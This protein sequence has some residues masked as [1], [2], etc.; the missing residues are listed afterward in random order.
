[1]NRPPREPLDAQERAL[2]A[3]LP[4]PHGRGEPGAAID[5]RI[6]A[7][8]RSA[9]ETAPRP[10]HRRRWIAPLGVA[11]TVIV[12]A[13][14]AWRLLPPGA[15]PAAS[16][17][18]TADIAAPAAMEAPPPP[19]T[20]PAD[21]E[22]AMPVPQR[23]MAPAAS[24]RREARPAP[25]PATAPAVP[26][27]APPPPPP[28]G[29]PSAPRPLSP[30]P[31]PAPSAPPFAAADAALPAPTPATAGAAPVSA[32][33]AMAP[34][35]AMKTASAPE[36]AA[37][38]R[39]AATGD[40]DVPPATADAPG[41]RDAWLQRIGELVEQGRMDEARESLIVFRKRYPDAV[42]PPELRDLDLAAPAPATPPQK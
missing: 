23:A 13:G 3:H 14:L 40:D 22:P 2:R 41:V 19:A 17:Q 28:A 29:E 8:A 36:H 26:A 21:A 34:R 42:L 20:P 15:P 27:A 38:T 5:A 7:A 11:A 39:T 12:A 25:P 35:A 4:R 1:M 6:L 32:S 18:A 31:A 10:A 37:A 24:A 30:A 33:P 16:E 9:T